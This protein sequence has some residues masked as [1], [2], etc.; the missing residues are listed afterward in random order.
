M[1]S[2]ELDKR[3]FYRMTYSDFVFGAEDTN[4]SFLW[5]FFQGKNI[6]G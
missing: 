3:T 2:K 1:M 5:N 6:K 4:E